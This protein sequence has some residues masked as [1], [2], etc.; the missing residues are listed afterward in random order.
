MELKGHVG[1]VLAAKWFPSGEVI[2]SSSS[3][4]SVRVWGSKDGINPR[5]F[6]GHTRA[7]TSLGIVGIGKKVVS[8]SLDGSIRMW[9]VGPAKEVWKWETKGRGAVHELVVL[10]SSDEVENVQVLAASS[11]GLE[12]FSG[13]SSTSTTLAEYGVDSKVVSM[14]FDAG[15]KMIATGHANGTVTL[16]HLES[17]EN[18]TAFKRNESSV[19]SVSF[20]QGDLCMGTA[21]GLPCRLAIGQD[22]EGFSISLKEE[23]AGWEAVGVETWTAGR[24]DSVWVA[25]G[26]G[27]IRRY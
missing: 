22:Q 24:D 20:Q 17:L 3:D 1:D 25:G 14:G 12:V 15:S 23:Y 6:K 16:R 27:G 21:A 11:N 9:D 2:L 4:L 26:L 18:V 13:S 7:V 8:G 19:Y 5:T 10:E